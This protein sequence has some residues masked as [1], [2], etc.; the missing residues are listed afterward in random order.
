[1]NAL[2]KTLAIARLTTLVAQDEITEP[3]RQWVTALADNH[4]SNVLITKLE[5]LISCTRCVSIWA[6][7]AVV[8]GGNQRWTKPMVLALAGSQAAVMLLTVQESVEAQK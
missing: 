5:Y 2:V 3:I 6:A 4:E 8:L 7:F 1:M